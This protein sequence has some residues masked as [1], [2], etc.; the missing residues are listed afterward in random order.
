MAIEHAPAP[1]TPAAESATAAALESP[2]DE[3][4]TTVSSGTLGIA[5]RVFDEVS[6]QPLTEAAALVLE[7][8][9]GL[10]AIAR[11][12]ADGRIEVRLEPSDF[13]G[14]GYRRLAGMASVRFWSPGYTWS[15]V[16]SFTEAFLESND[17]AT[18]ELPLGPN[19]GGLR[20]TV[21][22]PDG[23]LL[24]GARVRVARRS[25]PQFSPQPGFTTTYAPLEVATDGAGRFEVLGLPAVP[26]SLRI[27]HPGH[28]DGV[29]DLD[30]EPSVVREL[31]VA[32]Q[33][34]ARC[35]GVV[36]DEGGHPVPGARVWYDP[37][38]GGLPLEHQGDPAFDPR[39][40]GFSTSV[41]ADERG[42]FELTGL[43]PGELRL[44]AVHPD[45]PSSIRYGERRLDADVPLVWNAT[46][47]RREPIEF[48]VLDHHDR[49]LV[50]GGLRILSVSGIDP[51]WRRNLELSAD[52]T[53]TLYD[54]VDVP[55]EVTVN[56]STWMGAAP[57]YFAKD[58]RTADSPFAIRL[59]DPTPCK[60]SGHVLDQDGRP[61]IEASV[62]FANFELEFIASARIGSADGYF[63]VDLPPG[64]YQRAIHVEG[65]GIARQEDATLH[66]GEVVEWNPRVPPTVPL[67]ALLPPDADPTGCSYRLQAVLNWRTELQT[68]IVVRQGDGM[69]DETLDVLPGQFVYLFGR[70]R[71]V[72]SRTIIPV[73]AV[74]G[75][76]FDSD[77]G[78]PPL[79]PIQVTQGGEDA[80]PGTKLALEA[81]SVPGASDGPVVEPPSRTPE[82]T[83]L[84]QL[85]PGSYLASIRFPDGRS[86][87][88]PLELAERGT[89]EVIRLESE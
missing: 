11:A 31:D 21:V 28:V 44:W 77:G 41:V 87:E 46:L 67:R 8:D 84:A 47:R 51:P 85:P 76:D 48:H 62:S 13:H 15:S 2:V 5:V 56:P 66:P 3:P 68:I 80:P 58:L 16:H 34:G 29:M 10:R 86:A 45:D 59:S 73:D 42:A 52:G 70:D 40:L 9:G 89:R 39:L 50:G 64:V 17:A 57:L 20:G 69:L 49:P 30:V 88:H 82:G 24:E 36:T 38:R 18:L 7:P 78:A 4:V 75:G 37:V 33:Q 81:V 14:S 32:L 79:I 1:E 63:A 35:R 71:E 22:G 6:Q 54:W 23:E 72:V 26:M 74:T 83:W 53:A 12:D 19:A 65:K 61:P 43:Q 27:R 25:M 60:V 55:F